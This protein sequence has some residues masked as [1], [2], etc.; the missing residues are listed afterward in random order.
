VEIFLAERAN[1]RTMSGGDGGE[2]NGC[3]KTGGHGAK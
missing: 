2:G 3:N 1:A